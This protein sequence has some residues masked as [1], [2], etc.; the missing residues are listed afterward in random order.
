MIKDTV[1][2]LLIY[3]TARIKC[4]DGNEISLGT[5]FFMSHRHNDQFY[6]AL[7]TNKHVVRG[8]TT[9]NI[10]LVRKDENGSPKDTDHITI[11]LNNLQERCKYH[12]EKDTDICLIFFNDKIKELE[13]QGLAPYYKCIGDNMILYPDD[14]ASLTAIED[15][16]MIGYPSGIMDETNCKPVVRKGIT[17]TSLKLDYNGKPI[18]MIDAA[19]FPGSSGSPVFLKK[20][21][22]EQEVTDGGFTLGVSAAYSLLGILYAGPT[23]KI[24]G[25]IVVK[26]IPTRAVPT[27]QMSTT[28]NLGYV[29]KAR[30]AVELFE[31]IANS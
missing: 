6:T 12:P 5:G 29:V 30:K 17:A 2:D 13:N 11:T 26:D 15:I 19:C 23:I 28:M 9:A 10:E 8:Y 16:I 22:L 20:T 24:D 3:S 25:K 31:Q 7:V 21:G 1:A 18:F 4:S 14:Y 27:A